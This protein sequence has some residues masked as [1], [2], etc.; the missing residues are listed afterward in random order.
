VDLVIENTS[1]LPFTDE[2][3]DYVVASSVFEHDPI[4]WKTFAEMIR[5]LKPGGCV[6]INS[7]SNGMIHRYPI[8]VYRFYPDAGKALEKWGK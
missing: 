8:D 6:Y 1:D 3:F 7:P 5:V 2:S 4:F